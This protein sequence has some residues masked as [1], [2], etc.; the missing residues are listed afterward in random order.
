MV[1]CYAVINFDDGSCCI[2]NVFKD[3]NMGLGYITGIFF[4]K[5]E[6]QPMVTMNIMSSNE[7][8]ARLKN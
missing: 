8:K 6:H 2:Y 7:S 5:K 1:V 4:D 3:T